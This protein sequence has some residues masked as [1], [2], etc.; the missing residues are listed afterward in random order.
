MDTSKLLVLFALMLKLQ[1]HHIF[2]TCIKCLHN[3]EL[4]EKDIKLQHGRCLV[5][6]ASTLSYIN[7]VVTRSRGR[8]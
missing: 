1:A 6:T 5:L 8:G 7:E 2:S 3:A 4:L